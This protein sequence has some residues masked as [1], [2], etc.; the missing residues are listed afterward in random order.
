MKKN[1]KTVPTVYKNHPTSSLQLIFFQSAMHQ[2]S[3]RVPSQF[4]Q[5]LTRVVLREPICRLPTTLLGSNGSDT[6]F[7]WNQQHYFLGSVY[8]FGSIYLW[9]WFTALPVQYHKLES[10]THLHIPLSLTQLGWERSTST[11]RNQIHWIWKPKTLL[12]LFSV[13]RPLS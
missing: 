3:V 10:F 4:P 7:I 8:D 11:G 9:G 2:G 6:Q 1:P 5:A 13:E 12:H